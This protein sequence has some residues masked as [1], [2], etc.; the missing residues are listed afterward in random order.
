ML[1]AVGHPVER[2]MRTA[3]GDLELGNLAPGEWRE[4][5][6]DRFGAPDQG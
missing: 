3:I 4:E 5:R 2:L 6:F 1:E